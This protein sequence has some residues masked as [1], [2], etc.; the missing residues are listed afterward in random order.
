MNR[1]SAAEDLACLMKTLGRN[2]EVAAAGTSFTGSGEPPTSNLNVIPILIVFLI[3]FAHV[4]SFA[5]ASIIAVEASKY[6]CTSVE[7]AAAWEISKRQFAE[8]AMKLDSYFGSHSNLNKRRP[9]KC[10]GIAWS[11]LESSDMIIP[12]TPHLCFTIAQG[13]NIDCCVAQCRCA[14]GNSTRIS[15]R[16]YT[17]VV[18]QRESNDEL[19]R[20][21]Q[22]VRLFGVLTWC[23]SRVKCLTLLLQGV[24]HRQILRNT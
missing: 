6:V 20:T 19:H 10:T 7:D 18:V 14:C 22:G 12:I 15:G 21:Y 8:R 16:R 11:V 24:S 1:T 17:V 2:A 5:Q 9:Q 4:I 13:C 23:K 3:R